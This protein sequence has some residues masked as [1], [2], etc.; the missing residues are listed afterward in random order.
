MP[1]PAPA[2][3]P[4]PPS[5]ETGC[6]GMQPDLCSPNPCCLHLTTIHGTQG[7]FCRAR[8]WEL[9]VEGGQVGGEGAPASG[10]SG[11]SRDLPMVSALCRSS[12]GLSLQSCSIASI[13]FNQPWSLAP[14]AYLAEQ[15]G[16]RGAWKLL[17]FSCMGMG[18]QGG[19]CRAGTWEGWEV[20]QRWQINQW[21]NSHW[22][23]DHSVVIAQW[24][25]F[26]FP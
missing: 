5:M 19:M 4:A 24:I 17:N 3:A 26:V 18:V 10:F 7:W 14:Q 9:K 12:K 6:S 13:A 16:G 20:Q 23:E 1:T 2:P 22:I 8:G 15:L 11:C 21:A 25:M